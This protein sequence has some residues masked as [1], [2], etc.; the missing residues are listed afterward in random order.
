MRQPVKPRREVYSDD[1]VVSR[2]K[3]NRHLDEPQ[4]AQQD[5]FA[6]VVLPVDKPDE[7]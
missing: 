5:Y 1:A 7:P 3:V 4:P 2:D 6:L